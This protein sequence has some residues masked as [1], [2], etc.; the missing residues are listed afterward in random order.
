SYSAA[1]PYP[2]NSAGHRWIR[3]RVTQSPGHHVSGTGLGIISTA[4]PSLSGPNRRCWSRRLCTTARVPRASSPPAR[5]QGGDT[6][7]PNPGLRGLLLACINESRSVFLFEPKILYRSAVEDVPVN[8]YV[9]PIGKAEVLIEGSDVHVLRGGGP[10]SQ[11]ELGVSC[12]L[13]DMRTILPFDE[14]TVYASVLQNRPRCLIAHEAPLT[15]G[16][17]RRAGRLSAG[18]LLPQSG[19]AP[20]RRVAGHDT[21]FPHIFENFYLPISAAAWPPSKISLVIELASTGLAGA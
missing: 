17:R 19:G 21:P 10:P 8:G 4:A 3:H 16:F 7:R 11:S 18:A 20:V 1:H 6:A 14:E 2:A 15:G 13:I 9:L 5:H 12:E